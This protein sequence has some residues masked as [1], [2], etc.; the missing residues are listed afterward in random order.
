MSIVLVCLRSCGLELLYP[1][2]CIC[3][4]DS[5]SWDYSLIECY[6]VVIT[7]ITLVIVEMVLPCRPVGQWM[8]VVYVMLNIIDVTYIQCMCDVCDCPVDGGVC[9]SD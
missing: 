5:W 8:C 9:W 1:M 3:V 2:L 4:L 7:V 6:L